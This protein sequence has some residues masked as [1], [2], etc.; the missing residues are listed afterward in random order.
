MKFVICSNDGS[1]EFMLSEVSQREKDC[2]TS[3]ICEIKNKTDENS[4]QKEKQTR[5]CWCRSKLAKDERG[6]R[7]E[8]G[9][10]RVWG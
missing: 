2:V 4:Q 9:Q 5:R 8:K 3:L 7:E 1:R 6:K 10:D